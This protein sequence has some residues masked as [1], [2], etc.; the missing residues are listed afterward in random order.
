MQHQVI[1]L[2]SKVAN[3]C[4]ENIYHSKQYFSIVLNDKLGKNNKKCKIYF[5]ITK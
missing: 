5:C 2:K 4:H 1:I 3:T